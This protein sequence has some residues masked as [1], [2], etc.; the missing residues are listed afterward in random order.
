MMH[1]QPSIKK[2]VINVHVPQKTGRFLTSLETASFFINDF[3][4]LA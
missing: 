1:G 4:P 2:A 3:D